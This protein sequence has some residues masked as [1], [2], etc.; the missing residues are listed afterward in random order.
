MTEENRVVERRAGWAPVRHFAERSVLGLAA[1]TAIGLTFGVLLLLVRFH[2][3][4]LLDLDRSVADGLNRWASGSDTTVAILQQIASFGGRGFMIP[5]VALLVAVLLIRRRPRPALYLLVTGAGALIMDPSLKA[6]IGR[7]RPVVEVP[8]ASAPGN[9]F[10]SGHALGSMVVYGMIVLVFLPAMR[11][12]WRPWFAGLAALIVA[13]VGFTRIALGVHF[14]SDVLGGWLLGVAWI[15]VT[16]YA[17]RIWR[18]EAGRPVPALT[19]GLEPEAGPDLRPAPAEE[20]VLPHPWAKAAEILVGWV[21]VFGL[22]YLVGYSVNRWEPSFDDGV[23]RW[24]QTFRTSSL[25]D[26]SWMASKAGDTHAILL[27]SLFFCPLALALWR[28]WR[29]I[30]FLAL[31]MAGELTLFLCAAASVG[32]ARPSVEQLDGQMPTSSFPSG[33][34]AATMCLWAAI[35]IIV[36]ARVRQPWRWI[37][38]ALAVIMPFIVA[39]SRMYRGMHHPTD[40]LGATLLTVGWLTVLWFTVRPNAHAESVS[41]AAAEAE[42]VTRGRPVTVG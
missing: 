21:F 5:L 7:L 34:I 40:V 29:P 20:A 18:R 1:V 36:M 11:R 30:L 15:S 33:H 3:Q 42:Q 26:L 14:L 39:L 6:L 24:L 35:A 10:P 2:W 19:D 22:L 37:F 4:P 25:D 31:A 23:P 12:R 41:E 9:S 38:P 28:Q 17:F 32:R 27:I 8:V 13:A 16:A